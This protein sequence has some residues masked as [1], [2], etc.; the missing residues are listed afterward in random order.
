MKKCPQCNTVYEDAT[1]FCLNDGQPLIADAPSGSDLEE[2]TLI[3]REPI[4]VDF[5]QPET[6]AQTVEYSV[7]PPVN[8][9]TIIVERTRNTGKYLLFLL[10]GL[11]LGGS[12]VLA[13]L[14]VSR[15]YNQNENSANVVINKNQTEKVSV[16]NGNA[17]AQIISENSSLNSNRFEANKLHAEKTSD[18][19][20][21]FNGRVIT[22][23]AYVRSAPDKGAA[24]ISIFPKGDRINIGERENPNSP[25]YLVTCEHGTK[26]WMHGDTIEF[27]R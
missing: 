26:G 13:T 9:P 10:I 22:L 18:A 12:L 6:P 20:E 11:L 8:Q 7:A 21:D 23:N 19:D 27:S 3:R 16:A 25:W 2:P 15:I 17:N 1:Q 4:V 24:Q 14:L 5:N